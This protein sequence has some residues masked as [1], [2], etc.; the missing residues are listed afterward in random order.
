METIYLYSRTDRLGSH[1]LQY[2][3]L[4]IYAVYNNLFIAYEY[5]K[6]KY[7]HSL[8]VKAI[9]KYIDNYNQKFNFDNNKLS[10][11]KEKYKNLNIMEYLLDFETKFN[12]NVYFYSCDLLIITT[13]VIYNIKS[14]LISYYRKYIH[15]N[16]VLNI[17]NNI[18]ANYVIPFNPK[19]T[20]A[21]H[22]RLD[23]VADRSDYDGSYCSNYYK[24][25]IDSDNGKI[26]GIAN[27]GYC[28]LQTPLNKCKIDKCLYEAI[29]KYPTHEVIIIAAP[30]YNKIDFPYRIIRS[31]DESYDLFLLCNADVLILSRSTFALSSAFLGMAR[32]IWCPLWGHFVATGLYTKYD[33]SRFNY[34]F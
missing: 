9:L 20:I 26:Q 16:I 15:Q 19:K 14:D 18:P 24:N 4:I 28:N 23:D 31:D 33:N 34:F 7:R 8:F 17:N 2:L 11:I 27:L 29:Q 5:D 25:R 6:I 30:G 10:E 12:L 21:V 22:L 32:E 1:L 13:Q 3:T